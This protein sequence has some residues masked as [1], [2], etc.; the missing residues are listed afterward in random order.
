MKSSTEVI[1]EMM[2]D[3]ADM[4]IEGTLCQSCGQFCDDDIDYAHD[5][6]DCKDDE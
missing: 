2:G 6:E 4:I 3:V 1:G 5:C